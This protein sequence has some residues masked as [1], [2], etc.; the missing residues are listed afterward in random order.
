MRFLADFVPE[1]TARIAKMGIFDRFWVKKKF[2][3]LRAGHS[4]DRPPQYPKNG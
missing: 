2:T 1:I 3:V 4:E